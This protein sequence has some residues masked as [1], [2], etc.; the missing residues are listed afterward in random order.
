MEN[1][2]HLIAVS[3]TLI[4]QRGVALISGSQ[5]FFRA[6]MAIALR[7]SV[8]HPKRT[9]MKKGGRLRR[10]LHAMAFLAL[11]FINLASVKSSLMQV[12]AVLS[13]M[14]M[15]LAAATEICHSA[16]PAD[17]ATKPGADLKGTQKACPYCDIAANPSL[18][19]AEA[20]L[21]RPSSIAW[22]AYRAEASL[23][24]RGPPAFTPNAR[25]PPSPILTI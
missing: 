5:G 12:E 7:Q 4:W 2:A 11:A 20:P 13:P 17:R 9:P 22:V 18:C 1:V 23:G 8:F 14:G 21:A 19:G 24:A 6:A 3:A 25:G 16:A 10:S 15:S